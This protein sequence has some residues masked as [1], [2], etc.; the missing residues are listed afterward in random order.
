MLTGFF[1]VICGVLILG[2][3]LGIL[4]YRLYAREQRDRAPVLSRCYLASIVLTGLIGVGGIG[5]FLLGNDLYWGLGWVLIL[6]AP[7]P[8]LAQYWFHRRV[9]IER[10][11]L[12]DRLG[13]TWG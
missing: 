10:S 11:P 13:E 12:A 2:C 8:A 7:L 4:E 6:V 3:G 5:W 1:V 9:G